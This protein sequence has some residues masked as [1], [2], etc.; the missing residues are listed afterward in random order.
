MKRIFA[1]SLGCVF[2]FISWISFS[3][4]KESGE[5]FVYPDIYSKVQI[6]ITPEY[7]GQPLTDLNQVANKLDIE[8]TKIDYDRT[9]Q[10]KNVSVYTS[11]LQKYVD[12]LKNGKLPQSDGEYLSSKQS[13]DTKKVGEISVFSVERD[14]QLYSLASRKPNV[15]MEQFQVSSVDEVLLN[16]FVQQVNNIE[17]GTKYQAKLIGAEKYVKSTLGSVIGRYGYLFVLLILIVT[18]LA[19]YLLFREL[20]GETIKK[21]LGYSNKRLVAEFLPR[22]YIP[23]FIC[24]LALVAIISA[25]GLYWYNGLTLGMTFF[26]YYF[27]LSI[28]VAALVYGIVFVFHLV[29]IASV[30]PIGIIKNKF[31]YKSVLR[32][33]YVYKLIV[34]LI[35]APLLASAI[36]LYQQNVVYGNSAERLELL[37]DY[38]ELPVYSDRME[39]VEGTYELG[40]QY[41]KFF[42]I[43]NARGAILF[44]ISYKLEQ[45]ANDLETDDM[46]IEGY[47]DSEPDEENYA[48][49]NHISIN[50]EYLRH[51]PLYDTEGNRVQFTD[52]TE[53]VVHVLLPETLKPYEDILKQHIVHDITSDYYMLEDMTAEQTTSHPDRKIDLIWVKEGQSY[54]TYD[55]SI[56]MMHNCYVQ[57]PIAYVYNNATISGNFIAPAFSNDRVKI[58]LKQSQQNLAYF[59]DDIKACGLEDSILVVNNCYQRVSDAIYTVEQQ[60]NKQIALGAAYGIVFVVLVFISALT[61]I[62][63]DSR[64]LYIMG[65]LGYSAFRCNLIYYAKA[66]VFWLFVFVLLNLVIETGVAVSA[67]VCIGSLLLEMLVQTILQARR[68]IQKP[69]E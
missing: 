14:M 45:Q 38:V 8:V 26:Q 7:I 60:L 54:F 16:E 61:V 44:D 59:A 24:M 37:K 53:E 29:L 31:P 56:G 46:E 27:L 51:N 22:V 47:Q 4:L 33:T 6:T 62:H 49:A 18:I 41:K 28:A 23:T 63:A 11:D 67:G 42:A 39:T 55:P 30:Q 25:V 66:A 52:E 36:H 40:E 10:A 65:L 3:Y 34:V 50:Y 57:D 2:L 17:N 35:L 68:G 12:R 20:K 1:A 32:T 43:Q 21:I 19:L 13:E 48:Y 64:K 5:D 15:S 69:R 9:S 58:P